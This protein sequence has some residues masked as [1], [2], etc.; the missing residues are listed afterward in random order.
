MSG[1]DMC[2]KKRDPHKNMQN[3]YKKKQNDQYHLFMW[4][5]FIDFEERTLIYWFQSLWINYEWILTYP[6]GWQPILS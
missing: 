6:Q 2:P 5:S 1:T 3:Y 4:V